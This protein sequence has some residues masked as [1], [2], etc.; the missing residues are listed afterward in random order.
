[1]KATKQK[2][3]LFDVPETS[4]APAQVSTAPKMPRDPIEE[5]V[6]ALCDSIIVF[7]A[8]GWE[9]DLPKP[10][11]DRLPL[12]RLVHNMLCLEGKAS[13]DEACDCEAL[14][15]MYPR[16]LESPLSEQWTRIYLY[17]GTKVMKNMPDDIKR[18]TLDD[19]DMRQLQELKRWIRKKKV[20]TRKQK[21]RKQKTEQQSQ[22]PQTTKVVEAHY[23]QLGMEI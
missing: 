1:M 14:L 15:Y 22:Q 8:H 2:P 19:Y 18:E 7:P 13:W 6:G 21:A 11:L 17:L 20:E 5:I 10:L 4:T 23:E 16:T 12:D 9:H 3:T